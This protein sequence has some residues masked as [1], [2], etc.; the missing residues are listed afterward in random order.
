MKNKRIAKLV[1][2]IAAAATAAFSAAAIPAYAGWNVSTTMQYQA[3]SSSYQRNWVQNE[4][5]KFLS[6]KYWN[7]HNDPDGYTNY[8]CVLPTSSNCGKVYAG[9]HF[10]ASSNI[11]LIQQSGDPYMYQCAGFARKLA[12]DFYGI[13][14]SY[15]GAWLRGY[16]YA[17]NVVLRV[18][19]QLRINCGNTDH[20]VFI[21]EVSGNNVK[22][23]D[24]NWIGTCQIRWNIQAT[25]QQN[26]C[27]LKIGNV[28][29][30]M[31]YIYRPVLAGDVNADSVVN[32]TDVEAIRLIANHTYSYNN[33]NAS[34]ANEAADLNNDGQVT[35]ADW[36]I[37]SAQ[38]NAPILTYQRFLTHVTL[39]NYT[40]EYMS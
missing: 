17:N 39:E 35:M 4:M 20:T 33:I 11:V 37:A 19:D 5:R 13:D 16:C 29:Y 40:Y 18:G 15:G 12:Q 30:P 10:K 22:F 14:S 32:E 24:C 6:G 36:N 27:T 21:T 31:K 28:S 1:A 23:A 38:L 2:V 7:K 9:V 25:V 8:P 34:Y 26:S 3:I